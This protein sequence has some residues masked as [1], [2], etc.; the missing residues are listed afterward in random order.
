MPMKSEAQRRAMYSAAKGKS[1]LGI[2]QKVAKEFIK[3]DKPGKLPP[4]KIIR[5]LPKA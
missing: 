2:P 1:T 5:R 3:Q 4:R